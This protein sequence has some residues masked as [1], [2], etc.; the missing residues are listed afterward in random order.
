MFIYLFGYLS[1]QTGNFLLRSH[2]I[3]VVIENHKEERN[4]LGSINT[5]N[6]YKFVDIQPII[7]Q[8]KMNQLNSIV[9]RHKEIM[10]TMRTES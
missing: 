4:L 8:D 9:E 2:I 5:I 1:L 7:I 6:E 3:L 10:I